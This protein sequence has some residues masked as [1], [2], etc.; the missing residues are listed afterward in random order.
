MTPGP[1]HR[2]ALLIACCA[3]YLMLAAVLA[4]CGPEPT[5]APTLTP[6]GTPSPTITPSITLIPS[7][8]PTPTGTPTPTS[9]PTQTF[10]PSPTLF[11]LDATPIPP[12]LERINPLTA[13]EVSALAEW[14]LDALSDFAWAPDARTLAVSHLDGIAFFDPLTREQTRA[15]YPT[16]GRVTRIT[17]SPE[18]DWL[19]AASLFGSEAES[20]AS[21]FQLWLG[22]YWRPLGI[23]A[24]ETIGVSS[25]AFAPQGGLFAAAFSGPQFKDD[26]IDFYSTETWEITGT[27]KINQALDI[28]FSSDG[29][30][31]AIT[32]DRYA[33]QI[34]SLAEGE[35]VRTLPTS[36]TGE[37]SAMVFAPTTPVLATGH[38]DGTIR[39]WDVTTGLLL[40]VLDVQ[41][42]SVIESLA[43][44]PD[45]A[46]LASGESYETNL[47]R[48][49]AA[50]DGTLLRTLEGHTAGVTSLL[51]SPDG[52]FLVSGSYDGLIRLWGVR[53]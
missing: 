26:R 27:L 49:W 13:A 2:R 31:L 42:E 33:I 4:A 9:P 47:V 43:F 39:L 46:V 53:P 45:G 1:A 50:D 28:A 32:P 24:G 22:P 41:A 7:A 23:L 29:A 37:V 30:F 17:F 20:W 3:C 16:G 19:L 40:R 18:G 51:F 44:S 12:G 11:A 35:I 38:Y 52:G 6:S 21:N 25:V 48:L 14:K 15:L 10:T 8:T 34:Y 5:P 36:F